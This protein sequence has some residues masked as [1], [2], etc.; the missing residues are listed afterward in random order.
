LLI[1]LLKLL[2]KQNK[3]M[4]PLKS[5]IKIDAIK[6]IEAS[7]ES[8]FAALHEK[9]NTIGG[10][11]SP[12]QQY[13]LEEAQ[14]LLVHIITKQVFQNI[15]LSKVNLQELNRDELMEL[16]YELDWNGSWDADEEGQEP[17]TKDDLI[18]A[19]TNMINEL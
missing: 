16:A 17:M 8:I 4:K 3:Q 11:I 10:D 15:D 9:Y 13:Q 12:I 1:G 5:Q 6:M 2:N 14:E 7:N 18:E 19:I